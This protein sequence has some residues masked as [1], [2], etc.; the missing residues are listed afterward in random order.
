[1]NTAIVYMRYWGCAMKMGPILTLLVRKQ[2]FFKSD[3]WLKVVDQ[4][5]DPVNYIIFYFLYERPSLEEFHSRV[6]I[7]PYTDIKISIS[8][9]EYTFNQQIHLSITFFVNRRESIL[10][11]EHIHPDNNIKVSLFLNTL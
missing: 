4:I 3:F 6:Q 1:M 10:L 11:L 8:M 9:D 2:I 7:C 5:S